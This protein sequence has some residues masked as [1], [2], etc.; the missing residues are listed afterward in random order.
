MAGV[1]IHPGE[2]P[3]EPSERRYSEPAIGRARVLS[4]VGSLWMGHL[5]SQAYRNVVRG[6]G[7]RT[8]G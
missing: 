4:T 6:C 3:L 5:P 1:E 2:P 8:T 7:C